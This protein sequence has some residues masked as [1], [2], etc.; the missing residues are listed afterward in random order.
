[1]AFY[2]GTSDGA[3]PTYGSKQWIK[4]LNF[5]KKEGGDWRPWMTKGQISGMVENYDGLDFVTF[6]GVG[7]MAP[8]W[9]PE[10]AKEF[11]KNFLSNQPLA[12]WSS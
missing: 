7:H 11:M 10:A 1:M 12:P 6:R 2:S 3:I 9:N 8:Q 4:E 5:P